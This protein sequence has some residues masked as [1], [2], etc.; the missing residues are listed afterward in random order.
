FS[1]SGNIH[2]AEYKRRDGSCLEIERLC[3]DAHA[4][5]VLMFSFMGIEAK[6]NYKNTLL[7]D[8]LPVEMLDGDDRVE[9]PEGVFATP[10]NTGH[11]SIKNFGNWPMF[12]GYNKVAAKENT[13]V[14]L[15]IGE[16]PLL[17]FG[18]Y[19]KGKTGCFMSDCSPH[20]GS[21]EFMAW[22]HYSDMWVNILKQIAR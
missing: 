18:E 7:A 8:V 2:S 13:Q 19:D 4:K 10:A 5:G 3:R 22:E 9:A 11:E 12:L 20:W 14:V 15:N 16:D 6:A 1:G 21:R 17:V